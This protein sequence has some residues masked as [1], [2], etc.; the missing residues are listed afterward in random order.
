MCAGNSNVEGNL[1]SMVQWLEK[2]K[3]R[4]VLYTIGNVLKV[5][6]LFVFQ[7]DDPQQNGVKLLTPVSD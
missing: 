7:R 2:E 5:H 4:K 1:S 6:T 3:P